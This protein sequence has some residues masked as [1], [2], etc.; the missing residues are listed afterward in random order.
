MKDGTTTQMV[1]FLPRDL[2]AFEI[3]GG[4]YVGLKN[5]YDVVMAHAVVSRI[6]DQGERRIMDFEP[7]FYKI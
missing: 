4:L 7:A 2:G 1:A 6:E 3:V 5:T